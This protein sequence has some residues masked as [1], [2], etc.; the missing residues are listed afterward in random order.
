MTVVATWDNDG[1]ASLRQGKDMRERLMGLLLHGA[2]GQLCLLKHTTMLD[3]MQPVPMEEEG[4]K[5]GKKKV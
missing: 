4:K 1:W 5:R 2:F 3:V